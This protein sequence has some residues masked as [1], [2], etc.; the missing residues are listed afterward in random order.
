MISFNRGISVYKRS[1]LA[2]L[3]LFPEIYWNDNLTKFWYFVAFTITLDP[4][5]L[6]RTLI[7][8][9]WF[10]YRIPVHLMVVRRLVGLVRKT[11]ARSYSQYVKRAINVVSKYLFQCFHLYDAIIA[12]LILFTDQIPH[13]FRLQ[14]LSKYLDFWIT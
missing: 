2:W 6:T 11:Q 1:G 7:N 5:H 12:Y 3:F 10:Y 9:S 14:P 4:T 8:K 13:S